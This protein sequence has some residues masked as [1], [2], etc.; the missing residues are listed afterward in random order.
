MTAI[1][2]K[3]FYHVH[4]AFF[5]F[6]QLIIRVNFVWLDRNKLSQVYRKYEPRGID[7]FPKRYWGS[8]SLASLLSRLMGVKVSSPVPLFAL[9]G[10]QE[11]NPRLAH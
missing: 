1:S 6:F 11:R 8:L 3:L 2:F 10:Q 4:L 5:F 9:L 7:P